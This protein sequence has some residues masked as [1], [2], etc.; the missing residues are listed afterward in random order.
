MTPTRELLEAALQG[1][2][3]QRKEI[4]AKQAVK[5][6]GERITRNGK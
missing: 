2:D 6:Y 5:Q 1:F 3:I 4:E